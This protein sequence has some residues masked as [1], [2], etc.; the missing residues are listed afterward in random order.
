LKDAKRLPG[1]DTWE[2]GSF[3]FRNVRKSDKT[4]EE[5]MEQTAR[6]VKTYG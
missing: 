2:G 1:N 5:R 3:I 6:G 4:K